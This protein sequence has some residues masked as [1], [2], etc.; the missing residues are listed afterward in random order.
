MGYSR[1]T[2]CAPGTQ[3]GGRSRAGR[4][5]P[6][7]GGAKAASGGRP[8]GA[9]ACVNCMAVRTT[10]G[11]N[12]GRCPV[13]LATSQPWI[14]VSTRCR[15]SAARPG[16]TP[17]GS[18]NVRSSSAGS[19]HAASTAAAER[20]YAPAGSSPRRSAAGPPPRAGPRPIGSPRV[21]P[22]YRYIAANEMGK[23]RLHV[24]VGARR[25]Q[26]HLV[27][28]HGVDESSRFIQC[29]PV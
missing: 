6:G 7:P 8:P 27:G 28:S 10:S 24:P 17:M 19:P 5:P 16:R 12:A 18:A 23:E 13:A 11:A 25:G 4:P 21:M 22:A 15:V 14:T 26:A 3:R 2:A 9:L 20:R 29:A 1:P